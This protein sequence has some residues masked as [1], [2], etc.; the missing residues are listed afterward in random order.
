M[1]FNIFVIFC[2]EDLRSHVFVLDAVVGENRR[3]G[4]GSFQIHSAVPVVIEGRNFV[5]ACKQD[6]ELVVGQ[7]FQ[8]FDESFCPVDEYRGVSGGKKVVVGSHL[9]GWGDDDLHVNSVGGTEK[10]DKY[11]RYGS[12][13][14]KFNGKMVF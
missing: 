8:I 4:Q 5:V 12:G 14:R 9:F 3:I 11:G 7:A 1:L 2:L 6:L 13:K 10:E